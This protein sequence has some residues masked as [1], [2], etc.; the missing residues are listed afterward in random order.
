[1]TVGI[2]PQLAAMQSITGIEWAPEDG[3][4]QKISSWLNFIADTYP[5]MSRYC[6]IEMQMDYFE[7]CG[8]AVGYCMAKVGAK[9][10]FGMED[11][12]RFLW[13]L[14]WSDWGDEVQTPEP[15]DVVVFDFGAGRQHVTLFEKD[16]GDGYWACRGGNQSNQVKTSNFPASCVFAIRRPQVVLAQPVIAHRSPSGTTA[17]RADILRGSDLA[18][19]LQ[20]LEEPTEP[21][22]ANARVSSFRGAGLPLTEDGLSKAAESLGCGVPEIWALIFT[23]TDPP[24]GGFY[25]DKR[26]QILFER[27]IFHRLTNGRFDGVDSNISNPIPGGYGPGAAHQY[28][29]LAKAMALDES[30][31]LQSASWG[32]GQ[33]LGENFSDAGF[34]SPEELVRQSFASED[35][36]ILA[37]ANEVIGDGAARVLATHDWSAFARKYNGPNYAENHYDT[38]IRTWYEKFSGGG[39]PDLRVR[40]AQL[41]LMY[42]GFDPR[43]IDGVLGRFTR[44]AMNDY[45]V[46]KAMPLT[47]ALDDATFAAIAADGQAIAG[48]ELAPAG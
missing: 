25:K 47:S 8:L 34:S 18:A 7:W 17:V 24:H 27:H 12:Q 37:V 39:S 35:E 32:I 40:T 22:A 41:D 19:R 5:V 13:A 45:Q 1:M 3:Q 11:K 38:I 10:V 23:E 20:V 14:A 48:A 42:L 44:A 46:Q 30:A 4:S 36:Q 33:V 2:S 15:G 26:P 6:K 21:A 9:P 28:A 31:A 43:G 29:R 16:N